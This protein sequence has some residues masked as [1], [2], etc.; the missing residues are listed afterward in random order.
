MCLADKVL[1]YGDCAVNPDP[2]AHQLAEIAISSA[3]TAQAFGVE[4]VVAMLSYSTG[5]SG[6]GADVEKVRE[7]TQIARE[8]AKEAFHGLKIEGPIQ[9]DAAVDPGVAQTKIARKR[10]WQE[11]PQCL[12]F[13]TSTQAI[14]PTRPFK[15]QPVH[16]PLAPSFRASDILSMI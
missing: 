2:D 9:Y 10:V 16:W 12:S 3:R 8:M 5:E 4:P 7:A 1:V 15:G 6:K 11:R 13:Q 14:I